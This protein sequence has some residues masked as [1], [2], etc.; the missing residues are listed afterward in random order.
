MRKGLTTNVLIHMAVLIA[1]AIIPLAFL[2]YQHVTQTLKENTFDTLLKYTEERGRFESLMLVEAERNT[3]LM[4]Q[5]FHKNHKQRSEQDYADQFAYQTPVREG[6]K[7]GPHLDYQTHRDTGVIIS[8]DFSVSSSLKVSLVD[9]IDVIETMGAAWKERFLASYFIAD[10][11]LVSMENVAVIINEKKTFSYGEMDIVKSG[12]PENNPSGELRWS[13]P[14]HDPIERLAMIGIINPL[15]VDGQYI[16]NMCQDILLNDMFDRLTQ[17]Q[18]EGTALAVVHKS[19]QLIAHSDPQIMAALVEEPGRFKLNESNDVDLKAIYEAVGK[20]DDEVVIVEPE[21]SQNIIVVAKMQGPEWYYITLYP[22]TLLES[23]AEATTQL[24]VFG[25]LFLFLIEMILVFFVLRRKVVAPLNRLV[26]TTDEFVSGATPFIPEVE[27]EDEIG[28]L[29]RSFIKMARRINDYSTNLENRVSERT[30]EL[31]HARELAEAANQAKSEFLSNMSHEI[32]TPMNAVIGYAE[33]L[34]M[35]LSDAKERRYIDTI[36]SSSNNLLNLINDVLDL[37]KIEAGKMELRCTV[38]DVRTLLDEITEIF[39]AV[40]TEKGVDIRVEVADDVPQALILD[41]ERVRQ[42]LINLVGNA[43]KF[44]D[45]GHILVRVKSVGVPEVSQVN[46]IF[47]VEDSGVGISPEQQDR[48]FGVFEQVIDKNA[49]FVGGTG[50]GLAISQRLVHMMDGQ[51]TVD[52]ELGAGTTFTVKLS[53]LDIAALSELEQERTALNYDQINFEKATILI[54]DDIDYNREILAEYIK[55][56]GFNIVFAQNG[57]EVLEQVKARSLDLILL[58]MKMPKMDGYEVA[59]RLQQN[60]LFR[61][62]P[63]IAVT[64]SALKEDEEVISKLCDGYLRK[65]VQRIDLVKMLMDF[66]PHSLKETSSELG[67]VIQYS[68]RELREQLLRLPEQWLNNAKSLAVLCQAE[69]LK[70]IL[71]AIRIEYPAVYVSINENLRDFRF[72]LILSDLKMAE[73]VG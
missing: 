51:I 13:A 2:S 9:I 69:E 57:I 23:L 26:V 39:Y 62:I 41:R 22:K 65:P 55:S 12:L 4:K 56:W 66:L 46:L 58:D 17:K 10:K 19:G 28:V 14:Y 16:G 68:E 71:E 29:G 63:I 38:N 21:D 24:F 25:A 11:Y 73:E 47:E 59:E 27:R 54:A 15:Y 30:R 7:I 36:C 72:D 52:S 43:I 31:V 37:S 48:I 20:V 8:D 70:E 34:K 50:L 60:D 67:S 45:V 44:T 61:E 35:R 42:V 6:G 64:A 5:Q 32:R 49:T 53:G 40:S 3:E 18:L 33:L 1:V